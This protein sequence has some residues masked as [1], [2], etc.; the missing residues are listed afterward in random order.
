MMLCVVFVEFKTM[1]LG[2]PPN[3][4]ESLYAK[5]FSSNHLGFSII[6]KYVTIDTNILKLKTETTVTTVN[7]KLM[8]FER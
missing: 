1:S 8:E 7:H 6:S 3:S 5:Q 2:L 4:F